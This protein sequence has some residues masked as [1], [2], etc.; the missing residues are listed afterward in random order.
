MR[1][2]LKVDCDTAEGTKNGIPRLLGLFDELQIRASFFFSLGPDNSGRALMRVFTR[3]GF[4]R[5]MIRSRAPSLYPA[6]TMLSG[7]L[8]PAPTIGRVCREEIRSVAAAGHETGVH[9][10]DHVAWHDR[11]SRWTPAKIAAQYREL[12]ESYE[13]ILGLPATS[14]A[15]PGWTVSDD[16]LE[17][18]ERYPLLYTSDTRLGGPF[19]PILRG[20]ASK[21][22]EVPTTLPTLDEKLGDP[23]LATPDALFSFYLGLPA[24]EE[25]HTVHTEVEGS[26]HLDAFRRLLLAWMERGAKFPTLGERATEALA[27]GGL[28]ARQIMK[29]TLPGRGGTVA[30][31]TRE[32]RE[33]SAQEKSSSR[34]R[35][36]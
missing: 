24:G 22:V 18:R 11:L 9:A 32:G 8:L 12:H 4:L 26:A 34:P 27:R 31:G 10:W 20:G 15:A 7:T 14:S 35:R 33:S 21:I 30:S 28:P 29:I 25:V 6:R 19:F 16:Y 13:S 3:K 1:I 2:S 36:D 5:K 17:V 23:S